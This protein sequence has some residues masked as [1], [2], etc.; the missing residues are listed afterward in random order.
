[1]SAKIAGPMETDCFSFGPT[2]GGGRQYNDKSGAKV[3]TRKRS[4][5]SRKRKS[6]KNQYRH[7]VGAKVMTL[8]FKDWLRSLEQ[9]P[10]RRARL[11]T[12]LSA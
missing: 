1:M 5:A 11:R 7:L 4:D 2:T 10:A 3:C 8:S 6:L 12:T 9:K